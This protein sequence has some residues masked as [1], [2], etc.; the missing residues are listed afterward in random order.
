MPADMRVID[1]TAVFRRVPPVAWFFC[2]L[3]AA[4]SLDALKPL[5]IGLRS[6]ALQLGLAMT[7][8]AAAGLFAGWAI[9]VFHRAR[10]SIIPFSR[11][12]ALVTSGPFR[13]SRNPLYVALVIA[14]AS[15]SLILD[16]LWPLL[17][18]PLLVVALDRLV[19]TG[20]ER[21]LRATFGREWETYA[22]SVRRWM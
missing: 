16:S 3:A 15:F 19:I 17:L 4:W 7:L 14:L 13:I 11:P 8:L 20:E 5:P 6:F 12:A 10:T 18:T 2:C 21:M 9:A 1:R 22:S